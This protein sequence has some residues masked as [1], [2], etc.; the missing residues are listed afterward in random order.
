MPTLAILKQLPEMMRTIHFK[1]LS[2]LISTVSLLGLLCASILQESRHNTTS[3]SEADVEG[4]L[5][6]QNERYDEKSGGV[7]MQTLYEGLDG[8]GGGV[9]YSL[10][11]KNLA[12]YSSH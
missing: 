10:F 4:K 6:L 8:G 2:I 9:W 1:R 12:H 7:G 11:I 3:T 5:I